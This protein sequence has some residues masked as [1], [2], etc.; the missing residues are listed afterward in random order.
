MHREH[1]GQQVDPG[2]DKEYFL[3][4]LS[5]Q[6][7]PTVILS[8]TPKALIKYEIWKY[9]YSCGEKEIYILRVL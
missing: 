2:L 5:L 7:S 1:K 6:I 3:F 4:L 9:V 8:K